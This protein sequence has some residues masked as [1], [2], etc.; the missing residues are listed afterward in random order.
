LRALRFDA[1]SPI[2]ERRLARDPA[3]FV[4]ILSLSFKPKSG[5]IEREIDPRVAQNAYRLL[6]DWKQ[7]PGSDELG[8][9]I[10]EDRLRAWTSEARRLL[11]EANR[12]TIGEQ[13]IGKILAHAS[14][15]A[16][17]T[18]PP[19]AVRNMIEESASRELETGLHIGDTAS[20]A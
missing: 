14:V 16:D 13:Y 8:G 18:W 20:V 11:V 5:E 10:D 7:V 19:L 4:E 15:D 17:G 9:H 12:E 6:Q 1:S 2:L 3:F